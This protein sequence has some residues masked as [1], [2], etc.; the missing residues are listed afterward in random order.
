[1]S[2]VSAPRIDPQTL[3][4]GQWQLDTHHASVTWRVRHFGLSWVTGR[5]DEMDASLDFDPENPDQARL[6]ATINAASVSTGNPE[7][8][9]VLRSSGWFDAAAHT[10]I[11]FELSSVTVTGEQTGTA[12]GNLTLKGRTRPIDMIIEFH[13]GNYNFLESREIVGFGADMVIDRTEFGIGFL[14]DGIAGDAVHIRI[15]AEFLLQE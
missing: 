3:P 15:E 2:C 8:D 13:G 12:R 6:S 10:Q 4:S 1:M 7:F 9:E 5:F 14:P 11:L